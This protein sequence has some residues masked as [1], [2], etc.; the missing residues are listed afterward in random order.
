LKDGMYLN[1]IIHTNPIE[2]VCKIPRKLL[3]AGNKVFTVK[4]LKLMNTTVFPIQF[5]N[6]FILV[7]GLNDGDLLLNEVFLGAKEGMTVK[8]VK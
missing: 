2:N 5:M 7:R 8:I 4:D 6:E 1:G 3:Q